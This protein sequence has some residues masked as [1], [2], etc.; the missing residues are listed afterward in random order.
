[1]IGA[2]AW[3]LARC[4]GTAEQFLFV[5]LGYYAVFSWASAQRERDEL[6]FRLTWGSPAFVGIVLAYAAVCFVGYSVTYWAAPYAERVFDASKAE[7]GWLLGAP[8]AL[9][10]LLGV[11]T[12]GRVAD[13]LQTRFEW[14]RLAVIAFGLIAPIP[15]MLTA[16][17]TR[18]A[19]LFYLLS[20]AVQFA[21]PTALGAAAAA[22]QALVLPR[23]RA[24]AAAIFLLGATL[25]GLALGPFMAGFVSQ[26]TGDLALGVESTLLAVPIGL[27]ALF[28][29]FRHAREA[30]AA[31]IEHARFA[32]ES[33]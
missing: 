1:M 24:T 22:S 8:A 7:L 21:T 32:D 17:G 13:M 18:D 20:F 25:I 2:L 15:I 28:V 27:G 19:E 23:M 31:L 14:G 6:A 3:F 10:G 29:A 26:A 9:G 33:A 30:S 4:T 16:Y 12:G 11:I 5:G